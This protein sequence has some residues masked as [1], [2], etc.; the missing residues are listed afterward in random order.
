MEEEALAVEKAVSEVLQDGWRTND[1][2][3]NVE[4]VKAQGKLVG[5]KEMGSLVV[6][7]I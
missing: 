3:G 5:T 1:I 4:S 6:Q 7:K 2:A